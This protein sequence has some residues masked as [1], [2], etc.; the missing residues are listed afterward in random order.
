MPH[1]LSGGQ[2]QRVALARALAPEPAILLFDEPF[3]NLDASLRVQVRHEVRQLLKRRGTT[4]IFVTHDQEEAMELGDTIGV[5]SKGHLEQVGSPEMV[6]HQPKTQFVAEFMGETDFLAGRLSPIGVETVLGVLPQQVD[7]S[8]TGNS[9]KIAV[10]PDDVVL[11][12]AQNGHGNAVIHS[13]RFIGIATIYRVRLADGSV[14]ASLQPHIL[15]FAEG[16]KVQATF[17]PG[18]QLPIFQNG[19]AI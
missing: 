15:D 11:T 19:K 5:M 6:F 7:V 9:V 3:S 10:R 18:H 13:R 2:Q 12:P 1:E 8:H 4:A 16:D 17:R 14:V